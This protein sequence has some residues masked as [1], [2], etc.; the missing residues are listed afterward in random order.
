M[1]CW[2]RTFCPPCN[3]VCIRWKSDLIKLVLAKFGFSQFKPFFIKSIEIKFRFVSMSYKVTIVTFLSV[4][5]TYT[6]DIWFLL[7][8]SEF[9]IQYTIFRLLKLMSDEYC[10]VSLIPLTINEK[11]NLINWLENNEHN[12]VILKTWV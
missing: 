12:S 2:T 11:Y 10:Y 5:A 1:L 3:S 4:T 9:D 6:V 8:Y 7:S